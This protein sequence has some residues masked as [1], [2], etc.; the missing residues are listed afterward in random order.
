MVIRFVGMLLVAL[1]AFSSAI[2][3]GAAT[4]SA[5]K[6]NPDGQPKLSEGD[7][8]ERPALHE[9]HVAPVNGMSARA[10]LG[11]AIFSDATLSLHK[12]QSCGFC[13]TPETG[14]TS[15]REDFNGTGS[16]IEGSVPGLFGN[17]KPPSMA[18]MAF[19]PVLHHRMEDGET[20]IVGGAFWNGRATGKQLGN[21]VAD[22]ALAPFLNPVE[23]AL[24]DAACVV[25]RVCKPEDPSAYPVKLTD[26]WGQEICAIAFPAGLDE[27]CTD[28]KAKIK[29]DEE[30]RDH[31]ERAF[32]KIGLAVAAFEASD[33]V[34][35]YSSKYD[36]VLKGRA[37]FTDEEERG[38]ALYKGKGKCA[39][40]HVLDAGPKGEP[41]LFTDFTYDNLGVPRNPDNPFYTQHEGINPHGHKW[42]EAGVGATLSKDPL[43]AALA[44]ANMGK[45]KVPTLR[46]VDKRPSPD[47]V[48]AFMH[49]GY[50]KSLKSVVH[51]YNTRDS[52]PRCPDPLTRE[53]DAM[54]AGCWP[55]PEV[56]ANLNTDEMGDLKLT[57]A[58]ENAIVA[59][60]KTLSDGY[61][62]P[63]A[64]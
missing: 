40:C 2:T 11:K 47:F 54:K 43:Y 20:L 8:D 59:F 50:F 63:A 55:V 17:N 24:P 14:F 60:M 36:M 29:L 18:Y 34:N 52:K 12:N 10:A 16:V 9:R 37:T 51:F 31:V 38:L 1:G 56:E 64:E 46:N 21:A 25:K 62:P 22:Q 4:L 5:A 6:L 26:L 57:D 58:E 45:V 23:M 42:I 30:A 53:A 41:P 44:Q 19:A 39:N 27:Q 13:H 33:E 49:N 61:H 32:A 28:P 48:K 15:P 3:C 35:P 7:A